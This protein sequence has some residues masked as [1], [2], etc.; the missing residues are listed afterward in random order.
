[1]GVHLTPVHLVGK[2]AKIN[3][4]FCIMTHQNKRNIYIYV[5]ILNISLSL[6]LSHSTFHTHQWQ[7]AAAFHYE[8]ILKRVKQER[9]WVLSCHF[10]ISSCP[11]C[12]LA[13]GKRPPVSSLS[14]TCFLSPEKLCL[15][16]N[17]SNLDFHSF[18]LLWLRL[19]LGERVDGIKGAGKHA[20]K[21]N[22]WM[23]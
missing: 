9:R 20:R 5:S 18:L 17:P 15:H 12:P 8:N 21:C 2:G 23:N 3:K 4:L 14:K 19:K 22:E 1:M 13:L 6:S 11:N 7:S 10:M 16:F